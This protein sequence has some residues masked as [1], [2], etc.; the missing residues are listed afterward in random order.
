A[1]PSRRVDTAPRPCAA[2]AARRECRRRRRASLALSWGTLPPAMR[3][4]LDSSPGSDTHRPRRNS[5][6]LAGLVPGTSAAV[7]GVVTH[8]TPRTVMPTELQT[9][10]SDELSRVS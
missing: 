3:N 4:P 10:E 9:I 6:I 8:H 5:V 7:A 1:T 2:R